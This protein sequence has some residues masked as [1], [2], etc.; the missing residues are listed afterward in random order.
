M[1]F[2]STVSA[3]DFPYHYFAHINPL[4]LNP[5][6]AAINNDIRASVASYN[7]WAGGFK[8]LNDNMISFS[9]SPNFGKHK[10]S[11]SYQRT[12]GIG[13]TFLNEKNGPFN[14]NTLH[15]IYAYH[16]PVNRETL[17]SLG[18]C[19]IVENIGIDIN[20]LSPLNE[21]DPRLLTGNNNSFMIDGGFGA[22]LKGELY[23]ISFSVL[24]LAS[25]VYR[26][27]DASIENIENFRK[28]Y[29]S[30]NY[31]FELNNIIHVRP[32]FTL[33]NSRYQ[34]ICYDTS[35]SVDFNRFLM[36]FG[37]RSENS[38]F[39][40]TK[41]PFKKFVFTY[42]SENPLES[43]HMIGNGHTFSIGWNA[44]SFQH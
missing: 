27:N 29:L 38:I 9:F 15:L 17:L 43:N 26:F 18:V 14:Q 1:V 31:E 24:N 2:S 12:V 44:I 30:G 21:D 8:P 42:T 3:Q 23:Q 7:L 25:A 36:G 39:V 6:L 19:G 16:I 4:A 28:Y 33:R 34:N 41:I 40:Y 20:S 37:Y 13:V 11:R 35:F 32:E 10:R 5:S 22:S